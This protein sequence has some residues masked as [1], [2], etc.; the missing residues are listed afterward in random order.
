MLIA[1]VIGIPLGVLTARRAGRASDVGVR[2]GSVIGISMPVFW[3]GLLLQALF[4]GKLGWLPATSRLSLETSVLQPIPHHTGF[5][6]IDAL[7]SGDWSG[8][9]DAGEHL[10]L[11]AVT[12]AAYPL[13]LITRMTRASMLDVLS[14]D[15][16]RTART[17]GLERTPDPVA[18]RAPERPPR[19]AHGRGPVVRLP[20]DRDVLRRARL[21]LAGHRPVRDER[22]LEPG[23]PGDHGHHPVRRD[24]L[25]LHQPR[26]RHPAGAARS[27]G[28]A[29]V[30][31][32]NGRDPEPRAVDRRAPRR[33]ASSAAT[34]RGCSARRS[35][36][37]SSSTA[38]L[39]PLL[40][41]NAAQGRGAT[42]V[43]CTRAGARLV[44]PLRHRP[45]RDAISSAGCCSARAPR[46]VRPRRSWHLPS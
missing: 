38:A 21:Q 34:R 8:L 16:I 40:A 18:T 25:P 9:R 28:A 19:D 46:S 13:G 27:T 31:A 29:R 4:S 41:P 24:R 22:A 15:Y 26:R 7:W 17:F 32:V 42:D 11:P 44:A 30:T 6:V 37:S 45:P 20:P 2:V 23:L 5:A 33:S 1:V 43:A 35:A 36:R 14:Q 12:L 10:V 3:L 39:A